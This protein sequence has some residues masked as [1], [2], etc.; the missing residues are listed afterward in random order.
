LTSHPPISATLAVIGGY[1]C[2]EAVK[3]REIITKGGITLA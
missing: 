2:A 1:I 3:W